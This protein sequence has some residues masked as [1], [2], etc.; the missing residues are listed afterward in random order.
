ME[1]EDD[2]LIVG[3]TEEFLHQYPAI[4]ELPLRKAFQIFHKYGMLIIQAHPVRFTIAESSEEDDF[5][6]YCSH[7]LIAMAKQN[8]EMKEIPFGEWKSAK[9]GNRTERFSYPLLLRICQLQCEDML[10][11]IEVYNGNIQWAQEPNKIDRILK[12]PPEYLKVSAS[13]FHE[14]AH[15]GRG[16]M[17][18]NKRVTDSK[19]LKQALLGQGVIDW[20]R[21]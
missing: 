18:L 17:V 12:N 8:P 11:G 15:L 9:K 14:A 21:R 13:D 6:R 19:E 7:E 16:G 10:D 20:I 2:F 1:T 4:Y 3:I 5:R